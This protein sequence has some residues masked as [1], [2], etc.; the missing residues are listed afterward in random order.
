[1]N[2]PGPARQEYF[3]QSHEYGMG[4]HYLCVELK[5]EKDPC[6]RVTHDEVMELSIR[7]CNKGY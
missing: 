4:G 5:L 1:M 6:Y 7:R 3:A 2:S